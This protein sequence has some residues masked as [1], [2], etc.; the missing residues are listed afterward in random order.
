MLSG[1]ERESVFLNDLLQSVREG[2]SAAIVVHG[3]AGVGKTALLNEAFGS[4]S[5]LRVVRAAGIESEMELPFAG[6]QQLC[7]PMLDLLD[8]LAP[9]QADAPRTAFGLRTGPA[10]DRWLVALAALSLL[11][12]AAEREPLICVVDD[13]QWL[14]RASCQALGFAARRIGSEGLLLAFAAR[15]PNKELEGIP[16]LLVR[17]LRDRDARALLRSVVRWPLDERVRVRFLAEARGNPL[18]LLE[19]PRGL[20][21]AELAGGFGLPKE[22]SGRIQESF[23]RRLTVL[24]AEA[25]LMTLIAAAEPLGDPALVRRAA[26]RL[27]LP[28]DAVASAE[29]QEL[30]KING[31]VV[32]RHPLVRS[33]VYRTASPSARRKVHAALAAVT[34]PGLEPDRR[35]WHLAHAA[36]G[37]DEE[38]AAELELSAAR[39]QRRGGIA[40][41]AAF[42]EWAVQ[43]SPER[44]SKARRA[45][46]AAQAKY[47]AGAPE[48][49][50]RLL[51]DAEDG[52]LD[53]LEYAQVDMIRAQVAYSRNR[54]TDAPALLLRAARRLEPLDLGMAR[55]T[56]LDAMLAAHFAGRLAPGSLRET[57]E[58]ARRVPH[59]DGSSPASDLLLDGLAI[60]YLDGYTAAAPTLK[61]A[62]DAFRGPAVTLDEQ[63]RWL[64]PAAH[65]AMAL[66]DDDSYEA[67]SARHIELGREAGVLAV[68]PTAMT[69]RIVACAFAGQLT[70]A[71]ELI[72]EMRVL[73]SAIEIPMPAYGP[74]F[75]SAW[76]G[77]DEPAAAVIDTAI[78]EFT[79]S[80]EGAVLAFADYARAVLGNGLGR[81][82]DALVAAEATDSFAAEGITIYTQGLV[83]L[84]EAAAR[85]G[86]P[87]RAADAVRRLTQMTEASGTDW[88]AGI[89]AR[90]QALLSADDA[91]EALY[92]EAIERLGRS[93]IRPQLARAHLVYGEWLRRQNR[94]ADAGR[95]LRRAH[96]M[97]NDMGMDA[98]SERARRELLAT[99]ETARKRT[100]QTTG[101]TQELT[102]QEMQVAR[103]AREGLSNPEIGVRLFISAHTVQYHLSKVFAKLGI[104]SRGQLHRALADGPDALGSQPE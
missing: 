56:Y 8:R 100:V 42:L 75:V 60:A 102:A 3:E 83:E 1:R 80:G 23:L 54:G 78:R 96:A 73:T 67:L 6:L 38:V 32:F 63:L 99:G 72:G 57:A 37:P 64:W 103:L 87:E 74:L 40:A 91:A 46:A 5:G 29:A 101:T 18:A 88:A 33:A 86:A 31:H 97:F 65:V 45:L 20:S 93:R 62:V 52:P 27:G 48:A 82:E 12:E 9:P 36:A 92:R 81:Y 59:P 41:A 71:E 90:S 66:W 84:V 24:P 95:E 76:R 77:R 34:D 55:R 2:Q 68:L 21:P 44:G 28:A 11:S 104:T 69:T 22:L 43:L 98:F 15:E 51:L 16:E 53:A 47:L 7:M 30:L 13:C 19:L 39:A 26:A 89:R 61:E 17:G 10:P 14:D 85:T 50:H 70:A 25:R 4:A 58:A 49:A 35:A 94:R 79:G